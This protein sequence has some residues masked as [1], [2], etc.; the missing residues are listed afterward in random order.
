MD[1]YDTARRYLHEHN[2]LCLATCSD[3][4]PWVSPVF[5]AVHKSKLL[6]LSAPHTAHCKNIAACPDVAASIQDDY[7]DWNEIKGFQLQGQ[8]SQIKGDAVQCCINAYADKFTVTG[9]GAPPEIESA[10]NRVAWFELSVSRILFID[11]A[12]G[13]GHRDE[14]DPLQLLAGS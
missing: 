13:L 11:N 10:L 1:L 4:M 2:V 9:P 6:F 14:L 5:Y 8:V 7:S 12:K 3:T